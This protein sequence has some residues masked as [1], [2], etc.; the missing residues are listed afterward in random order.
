MLE[1]LGEI[2]DRPHDGETV[3]FTRADTVDLTPAQMGEYAGDYR[4]DEMEK[5]H[6]WKVEKGELAAHVR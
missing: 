3:T 5:T 2:Y 4:S 1:V 6:T